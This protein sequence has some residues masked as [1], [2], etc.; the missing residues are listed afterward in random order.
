MRILDLLNP[1]FL[2]D[3]LGVYYVPAIF[4]FAGMGIL[5]GVNCG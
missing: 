2:A 5:V 4:G 3:K 1:M